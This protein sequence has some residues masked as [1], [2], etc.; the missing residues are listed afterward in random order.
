MSRSV[1]YV[2]A[3]G[4]ALCVGWMASP[5]G[6]QGMIGPSLA[7]AQKALAATEEAAIEMGVGGIWRTLGRAGENWL[8]GAGQGH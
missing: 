3:L 2:V 6:A 8:A 7:D 1:R 4:A 5:A